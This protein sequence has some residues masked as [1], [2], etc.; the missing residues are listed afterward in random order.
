MN[1][2]GRGNF[3]D[4]LIRDF[5]PDPE[6]VGQ[7]GDAYHSDPS[8]ETLARLQFVVEPPRQ[9]LFRRLNAVPGGTRVL[10][11]MRADLLR[12]AGS[13]AASTH[14]PI[15]ADLGHLLTSWFNR[16]FLVLERID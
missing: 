1:S 4:T 16:G 10:V 13:D 5:S 3:F 7:A 12:D 8:P 15:A 9:E 2:A 14:T 6:A 11:D